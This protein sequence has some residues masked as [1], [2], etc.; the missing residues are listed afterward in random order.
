[1]RGR[2]ALTEAYWKSYYSGPRSIHHVIPLPM[3]LG[4]E[5]GGTKLQTRRRRRRWRK[6]DGLA[7]GRRLSRPTGPRA[8]AGKSTSRRAAGRP[9]RHPGHRLRLRRAGRLPPGGSSRAITS[10][11]WDDFPLADW[12]RQTLGLPAAL[13]NDSDMAGLGEARF[14]AGRGQRVV[15]YTN[16]GSGIGGA[17]VVDGRV[18]AGSR[19][20]ASELGHFVPGPRPTGPEQIV[21]LAASGW[22]IAAGGPRRCPSG[23]PNCSSSTH[24]PADRLTSKMVA[25]AAAGRRRGGHGRFF[26]ARRRPTAGPSRR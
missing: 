24:C 1:M 16:V 3:F 21:E 22:A 23:R 13:A 17:L 14:G 7:A 5:I 6:A 19:G 11:G 15:F 26:A 20:I 8:S 18:Y 10:T 25:E 4:I 9:V 12:C 2:S